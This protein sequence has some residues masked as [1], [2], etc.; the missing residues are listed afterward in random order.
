[1]S[2]FISDAMAQ[3]A[4]S[5]ADPLVTF[6]PLI[7]IFVVFYFLMIRPQM[8]RQKEHQQLVK[9]LKK[10]DEVTTDGGMLGK[11]VEAGENYVHVEVADNTVIKIRRKSINTVLP[12]GT[13]KE[14]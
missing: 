11:I 4:T 10:G 5:E 12:K 7:L 9:A 14:A 13:L 2:F 6:L 8:K 3:T 1:M